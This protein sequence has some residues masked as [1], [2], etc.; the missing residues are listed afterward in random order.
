MDRLGK[1]E[2]H[3]ARIIL[4]RELGAEHAAEREVAGLLG[5]A[6]HVA[7]DR[8]PHVPVGL[9]QPGQR[10]QGAAVDD[11][12]ARCIEISTDRHDRAGAH[13]DVATG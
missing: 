3:A 9:D 12:R 6:S 5:L 13:V 10:D 4:R 1:R 11:L 8:A 2:P 7:G